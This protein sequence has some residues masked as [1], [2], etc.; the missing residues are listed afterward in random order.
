MLITS[1]LFIIGIDDRDWEWGE[2][3]G[4]HVWVL[5][6]RESGDIYEQAVVKT[7]AGFFSR[8]FQTSI[9]HHPVRGAKWLRT[10]PAPF[11]LTRSCGL[12]PQDRSP[13]R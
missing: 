13:V 2:R 7:V 4:G 5:D 1:S 6:S 10:K 9:R 11:T 8:E 3:D 12:R